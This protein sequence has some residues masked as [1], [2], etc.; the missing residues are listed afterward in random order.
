[1]I[2]PKVFRARVLV[3]VINVQRTTLK[4]C[5]PGWNS[6]S[7]FK[8]PKKVFPKFRFQR[9]Y[10]FFAH[11]NMAA[12]KV[13]DLDLGGPAEEGSTHVPKLADLVYTS[14]SNRPDYVAEGHPVVLK[15]VRVY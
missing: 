13:A 8:V 15:M 12:T 5:V 3:R 2:R 1:M 4:V 11:A 6:R 10:R 14:Q 7:F 9:G